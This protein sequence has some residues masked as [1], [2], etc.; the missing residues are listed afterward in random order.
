MSLLR[1]RHKQHF[2]W[3]GRSV[4]VVGADGQA[5]DDRH[6]F[7][8]EATRFLSRL[9]L[10]ADG[11]RLDCFS[12]AN[13]PP[14]RLLAYHAVRWT[15][16]QLSPALFLEADYRVDEWL[17]I[18]LRF[19]N[20]G[21]SAAESVELELRVAADFADLNEVE[22]GKR[23]E[24]ADVEPEWS[25]ER[26]ELRFAYRHPK[27]DRASVLRVLASPATAAM[28]GDALMIPVTV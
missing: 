17:D 19:T 18:E 3:S 4:L 5:L 24:C 8:L 7:F 20:Y 21:P 28:R 26:Q 2:A 12:V 13:G 6:G 1:A 22:D 9:E 14:D 27:L 16:G 11:R 23:Y 15:P 25:D 10:W